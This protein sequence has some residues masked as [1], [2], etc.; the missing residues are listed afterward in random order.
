MRLTEFFDVVLQS[1]V[2]GL[3]FDA[4]Q[5]HAVIRA[6]LGGFVPISLSV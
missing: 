2:L 4:G 3:T 5:L 1:I 6:E